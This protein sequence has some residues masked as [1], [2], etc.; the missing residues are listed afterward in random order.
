MLNPARDLILLSELQSCED[1]EIC[2]TGVRPGGK[3]YEEI[4]AAAGMERR[5]HRISRLCAERDAR[6]LILELKQLEPEYNPSAHVLRQLLETG[7]SGSEPAP[8]SMRTA[9]GR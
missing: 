9:A 4:G 5:F 2:D 3:L 8:L 1:I 6:R 7:P